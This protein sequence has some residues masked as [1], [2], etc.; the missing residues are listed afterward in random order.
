M[1]WLLLIPIIS[2]ALCAFIYRKNLEL[3][4]LFV[5]AAIS[6]VVI[7]ISFYSLKSISLHDVEY[8]GYV[9][10]EA[11]YYEYYSTWVEQTCTRQVPCGENCTTDSQ[12]RTTCTTVYCTEYY[13]CSYCDTNSPHWEMLDSSGN[14]ISITEGKYNSLIK[15]WS[16]TPEFVELN[17][18]IDTNGSCGV[19]GDMYSIQWDEKIESSECSVYE[20]SFTNIL[21]CNHSAFNYPEITKEQAKKEKLHDYPPIKEYRKQNPLLGLKDDK[22]RIYLE[23]L[24][25]ELGA[26]KKVKVFTLFFKDK[27]IKQSFL[28]EAYWDGGNQNEIIVCIGIDKYGNYKWVRPFSWCDNKLVLVD[29]R[30]DLMG[31]GKIDAPNMYNVYKNAINKSWKYKKF[32]D[33]NYLSFEPTKNQLTFIGVLVVLVS[34]ICWGFLFYAP[35]RK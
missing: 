14:E 6:T 35:T 26:S 32:E 12:G 1:W 34:I 24:N 15:Q 22:L 16:A 30:E 25:G 23:Y 10:T 29:I 18:D 9:I 31:I 17:R 20:R 13:D 8:N 7:L 28:Q 21:K 5:P 4:K 19:D 11:R 2:S 27:E 3:W 33:F